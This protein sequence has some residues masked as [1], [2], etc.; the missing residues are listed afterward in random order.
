MK[1]RKV[2]KTINWFVLGACLLIL[3]TLLFGDDSLNEGN[4]SIA[5]LMV[6]LALTG[7]LWVPVAFAA[8][9]ASL[10]I[11]YKYV[12][13]IKGLIHQPAFYVFIVMLWMLSIMF[14]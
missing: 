6:V 14:I 9:V 5:T 10:V 1:L 13:S 7:I 3:T 4:S 11:E 2:L 8:S 12:D